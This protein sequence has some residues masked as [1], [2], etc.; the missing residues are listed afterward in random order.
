LVRSANAA[1]ARTLTKKVRETRPKIKLCNLWA[2]LLKQRK[3][4]TETLELK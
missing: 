2:K 1:S 3:T 4:K